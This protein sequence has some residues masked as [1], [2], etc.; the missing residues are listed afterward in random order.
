MKLGSYCALELAP[1]SPTLEPEPLSSTGKNNSITNNNNNDTWD[2]SY[3]AL[4]LEPLSPTMEN[5]SQSQIIIIM[6][7]GMGHI[8]L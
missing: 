8:E 6:I 4:E 3:R 1:L 7:L 2:G 5:N